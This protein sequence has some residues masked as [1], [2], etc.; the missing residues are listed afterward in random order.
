M[1]LWIDRRG[2]VFSR[3][4]MQIAP[5]VYMWY[6]CAMSVFCDDTQLSALNRILNRILISNQ[7]CSQQN[8]ALI[9]LTMTM[10]N[11]WDGRNSP[12]LLPKYKLHNF[13]DIIERQ[14]SVAFSYITQTLRHL[15]HND[16]STRIWIRVS[17]KLR[18]KLSCVSRMCL[19]LA[20]AISKGVGIE[21]YSLGN[22]YCLLCTYIRIWRF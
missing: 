15:S 4:V 3:L 1:F 9:V 17:G 2:C 21:Y 18:G 22:R 11:R 20:F 10:S 8:F 5:C 7:E 13:T 19:L 6:E 12:V 14:R 16:I